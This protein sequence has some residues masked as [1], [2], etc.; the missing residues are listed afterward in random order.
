M[1]GRYT[2][3]FVNRSDN[4]NEHV[5]Q[6]SI[7]AAA[8]HSPMKYRMLRQVDEISAAANLLYPRPDKKKIFIVL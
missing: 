6:D 7:F 1:V 8:S 4:I 2:M 3:I 5:S